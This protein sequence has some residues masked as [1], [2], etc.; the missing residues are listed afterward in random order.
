[1]FWAE[2]SVGGDAG[3]TDRDIDRGEDPAVAVDVVGAELGDGLPAAEKL[4][5]HLK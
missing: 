2:P 1:M 5:A 4:V 3:A